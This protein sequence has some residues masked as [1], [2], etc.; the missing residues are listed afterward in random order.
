MMP[1]VGCFA[2]GSCLAY[3][4]QQYRYGKNNQAV[5]QLQSTMRA[6]DELYRQSIQQWKTDYQHLYK[7]YESLE[8][9]TVERDYEEFKAPDADNDDIITMNEFNTYVRKYLASFPELSEQDFPKFEEFDLN[10][11]GKVTF[12]EWQQFLTMQKLKEDTKPKGSGGKNTNNNIDYNDL[13]QVLYDQS[14]QANSF[15]GLQKQIGSP[16]EQPQQRGRR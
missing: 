11:D 15:S 14:A 2:A 5:E 7:L 1:Y 10:H 9:E 3:F 12:D 8:K 16:K 4:Y 13:L 6:N